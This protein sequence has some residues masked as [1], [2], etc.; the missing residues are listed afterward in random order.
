MSSVKDEGIRERKGERGRGEKETDDVSCRTV[1]LS[2]EVG[3]AEGHA[4]EVNRVASPS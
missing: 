3:D 4:E 1:E 2:V